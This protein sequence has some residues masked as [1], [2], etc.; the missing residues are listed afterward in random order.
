MNRQ[1]CPCSPTRPSGLPYFCANHS[2]TR[3]GRRGASPSILP[4]KQALLLLAWEQ[5]PLRLSCPSLQDFFQMN[6]SCMNGENRC[7]LT[8]VPGNPWEYTFTWRALTVAAVSL[9][10][11]DLGVGISNCPGRRTYRETSP[12]NKTGITSHGLALS[13]SAAAPCLARL[14]GR[15]MDLRSGTVCGWRGRYSSP[16]LLWKP[17]SLLYSL[18]L[19]SGLC[20]NGENVSPARFQ[21]CPPVSLRRP[22][23]SLRYLSSVPDLFWVPRVGSFSKETFPNTHTQTH[24]RQT[25]LGSR[26]PVNINSGTVVAAQSA[27]WPVGQGSAGGGGRLLLPKESAGGKISPGSPQPPPPQVGY[28]S[29][30]GPDF[31]P[32][33]GIYRGLPLPR[34]LLHPPASLRPMIWSL[35]HVLLCGAAAAAVSF[36]LPTPASSPTGF[37]LLPAG[38][39]S[40]AAE[41]D[42]PD[43]ARLPP[44]SFAGGEDAPARRPSWDCLW[45]VPEVE[46]SDCNRESCRFPEIVKGEVHRTHQ[47]VA[48]GYSELPSLTSMFSM[49]LF[50]SLRMFKGV[51]RQRPP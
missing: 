5:V 46:P 51:K 37:L 17:P 49:D 2:R 11:W 35:G 18:P 45:R 14:A 39:S 13:N 41:S 10:L 23:P 29:K 3:L 22:P 43:P 24:P 9:L 44:D 42:T 19:S 50:R 27:G 31:P 26:S 30:P 4:W 34:S 15:L 6:V 33:R 47:T 38:R 1:G 12:L 21:G 25:K 36:L 7:P 32:A 20:Q 28:G 48:P 8:S 40:R 16:R